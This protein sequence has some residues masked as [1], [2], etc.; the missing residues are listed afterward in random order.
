MTEQELAAAV[1]AWRGSVSAKL[2][3]REL[4]LPERTLNFIEQGRGFR[5]PELLLRALKAAPA[6]S[7]DNQ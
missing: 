4:G 6:T 2:A 7:K 1:K 3:A 5:Y